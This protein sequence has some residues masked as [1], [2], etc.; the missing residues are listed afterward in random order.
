MYVSMVVG[1]V[2]A[3]TDGHWLPAGV[4]HSL[5]LIGGIALTFSLFESIR[6]SDARI[7]LYSLTLA[8][9]LYP[10][11]AVIGLWVWIG[12][13]LWIGE[14]HLLLSMALFGTVLYG[15][16]WQL[17]EEE[18]DAPADSMGGHIE[19]T[20]PTPNRGDRFRIRRT[21]GA[22]LTLM[23]PR[24][25]WLLSL[26]AIAG[27]SLA[28]IAGATLDGITLIATL[29]GGICAIG[30]SGT[31]NHVYERDR[32]RRMAR[33]ADRPVATTNVSPVRAVMFGIGLAAIGL[34]IL[35]IGTT[36]LAVG[37]TALAIVY[38]AV[39]YTVILKPTTT[40]N[41][42]IGGGAGAIPALIGWAA[43]TGDIGLP[44]L[45]L[46]GVVVIW[47][48]AHFYNLAIVYRSDYAAGGYPMLPIVKGTA[49]TRRRIGY[50]LAG[51]C[52]GA[53][54]LGLVAGLGPVFFLAIG[55]GGVIFLSSY[56]DQLI[57]RTGQRT[58]RTFHASNLFL[59]FVLLGIVTEGAML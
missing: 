7:V 37:L 47:T 12:D 46:A 48:P 24:L 28:V 3:S 53:A 1:A 44:A 20:H 38:Y 17:N 45:V 14:L 49:L 2:L 33:T 15:L 39:I 40:W 8:A 5:A 9:L 11:Q 31:F 29:A 4:H 10:V 36:P 32:D 16:I 42:A 52:V 34:G 22:Y 27:I 18:T 19:S 55:V 59:A 26:L 50:S 6:R 35:W 30:A 41:I 23:K 21:I 13:P 57:R 58:Y 51:A 54:F 43:V 25:M 56:I